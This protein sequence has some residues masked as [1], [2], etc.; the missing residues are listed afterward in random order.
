V[1]APLQSVNK[2]IDYCETRYGNSTAG[3][4]LLK[5]AWLDIV[6]SAITTWWTPTLTRSEEHEGQFTHFYLPKWCIL[7]LNNRRILL[8]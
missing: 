1:R 4:G 6:R 2:L 3:G 5:A 7:I 8:K